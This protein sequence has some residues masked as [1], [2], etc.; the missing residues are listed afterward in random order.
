VEQSIK[1]ILSTID[2]AIANFQDSIP[3]IQKIVYD[4]L[5]P[6][7]KQLQIKNGKLLNNIDNL[8]LLGNL[9]NKLEKV[10]ISV[11]YKKSVQGFI[12]SFTAVSN[13]NNE[14]FSQFNKKYT[15]KNTLPIIKQLAVE[16][17][18]NDLI[19]QGLSSNI[20]DPIKSILQQ[21]IT[22][23]GDYVKL[24]E[25]LQNHILSNDSGDGNLQRYTK[26]ITTDAIHQYN[27]QY[28]ETVAQDL[29][30][31]W[32]RYIG[33]SLTTSREFCIYLQKKQWVHKSEL[34]K[35]IDG[36]IDGHEC[37]LSK[38][39]GLPVGMIPDT[40]AD[41]FKVRRGGYNCGHQFFWVP[42]SSVPADVKARFESGGVIPAVA[43]TSKEPSITTGIKVSNA[44]DQISPQIKTSILNTL[45]II[46]D[47]HEDGELINIPIN[48]TNSKLRLG[49]FYHRRFD[50]NPVKIEISTSG[51]SKEMT[52]AHELGH[53]IDL[54]ATGKNKTTFTSE[55]LGSDEMDG[56]MKAIKSSQTIVDIKSK[57]AE[58]LPASAK[59]YLEY[60]LRPREMWARAYAQY[61]ASNSNNLT[62]QKQLELSIKENVLGNIKLQWNNDE[63]K[64]IEKEIN[65][66][67]KNKKWI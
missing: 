39:T 30:F 12:D 4:E 52:F 64:E 21:N 5:Q 26:Q 62:M 57:Y 40:N 17:T 56:I 24:Q 67:F 63:F 18:I 35:I 31:S 8:R 15:P 46:D 45:G 16:S 23:G 36:N 48:S 6:L 3:G 54:Y 49:A 14:Y 13:L 43:S 10:I 38:T 27:A 60:L 53:Y 51:K 34:P 29:Q 55:G 22:T 19:G 47:I 33:S 20:I 59:D 44:F 9:Q 65:V 41:N 11:E 37:K 2:D 66:Y 42:D 32:G 7:I 25:Q 61:I 50:A 58:K 1:N 28:G